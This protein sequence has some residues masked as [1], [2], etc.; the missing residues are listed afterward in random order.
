MTP[1]LAVVLVGYAAFV[2]ALAFAQF[3]SRG[4]RTPSPGDR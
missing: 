1:F 4:D 2:G 3:R